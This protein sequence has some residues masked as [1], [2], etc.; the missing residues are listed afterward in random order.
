MT[1]R[2]LFGTD[3]IRGRFGEEPLTEE[4]FARLGLALA[5]ELGGEGRV[6][7]GRD[8][9]ESGPALERA[10]AGGLTAG[11]MAPLSLGVV[12]TPAVAALTLEE[13]AAAGAVISASHNPW[14]DNGVKF[15]DRNGAKLPDAVEASVEA[16]LGSVGDS[17]V[18]AR[19]PELVDAGARY[20]G[21]L[22]GAVP[23]LDLAG[24]SVGV[25]CAHGATSSLVPELLRSLG[26]EVATVGDAPDGRNINAGVGS[27]APDALRALVLDRRLDLGV[28][29]DGD[30]DRVLLV[31][32]SGEVLDG[33][34]LLYI[35][36]MDALELGELKPPVVGT[37]MT[38]L[39]LER[40]L[41]EAG[42]A[43]ERAQVGD[44]YVL[45]RLRATGG[46]LGG[47]TSGH[48]L[49]LDRAT[50]GDGPLAALLVLAAGTRTGRDL[51]MLRSGWTRFPQRLINVRVAR[52]ADPW[53]LPGVPEAVAAEEAA[54][55]SAGRVVLRASG[56]EP[57]IRVMVEAET[58]TQADSSAQRIA[59]AVRGAAG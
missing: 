45:E 49:C 37:L 2:Q 48:I 9:R 40:A 55:E 25:D 13:G 46:T 28:A 43:V 47:E 42:I 56:T 30:G 1:E 35:L 57:L 50:T 33:D 52:R 39:G 11:G 10:L 24:L 59:D 27:T 34:D 44:R 38:N 29:F 31:D 51:A 12:P 53:S 14:Q 23:G 17:V 15:F 6:L 8:T 5:E 7:I 19:V 22:R 26:A 4:T 58:A 36:A 21:I 20:L 41:T 54:L 32:R 3:G 18:M 16:R